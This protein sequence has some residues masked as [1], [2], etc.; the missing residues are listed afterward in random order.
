MLNFEKFHSLVKDVSSLLEVTYPTHFK[1]SLTTLDITTVSLT[2][3]LK[4]TLDKRYYFIRAGRYLSL[5]WGSKL[6]PT[7]YALRVVLT[8]HRLSVD[9][10]WPP[11]RLV[12]HL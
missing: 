2:K 1:R 6:C 9:K 4:N 5:P 8:E 12:A 3:K 7:A 11:N 10:S